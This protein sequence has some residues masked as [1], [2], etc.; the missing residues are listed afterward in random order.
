[1]LAFTLD[2]AEVRQAVMHFTENFAGKGT[3]G[4]K[5]WR[6][7]A[8]GDSCHPLGEHLKNALIVLDHFPVKKYAVDTVREKELRKARQQD[9]EDLST[10]LQCNSGFS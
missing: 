5:P 4:W 3:T 7:T 10:V 8:H 9:Q 1:M 6:V 2:M